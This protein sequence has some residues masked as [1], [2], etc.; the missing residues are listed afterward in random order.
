MQPGE[1]CETSRDRLPLAGVAATIARRTDMPTRPTMFHRKE[2]FYV[3]DTYEDEG[4]SELAEHA[5]LNPGTLKITH[6]L[7]DEILWR[8]Q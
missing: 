5:R 1:C 4:F 8:P 6:A 7:T 3:I 2:T